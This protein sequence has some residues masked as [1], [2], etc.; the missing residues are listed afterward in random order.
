M[1][2]QVI[3]LGL[4]GASF[5][6]AMRKSFPE[7]IISGSDQNPE[8][9]KIALEKRIIDW[10]AE[11][12]GQAD[13]VIVAVPVNVTASIVENVLENCGADTLVMDMG[14]T[15]GMICKR[16]FGHPNRK[17]FLAA[18]PIAGTEFSGP[19]AG[20]PGLFHKKTMVLCETDLTAPHLLR[21]ALQILGTLDMRIR[22]M[23]PEAHDRHLA[24]VSHLS[25]ISSFMLGRTVLD[26]EES[27]RD[28]L[29]L[30][31][32]GFSSTVRLAKSSPATWTP[33]FEQNKA[34]VL[35][36]LNQ[37]I[38]HLDHFRQLL[39]KEDFQGIH[40]EMERV[41]PIKEILNGIQ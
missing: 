16:L 34:Q 35:E 27:E 25:H 18:H 5:A 30:A 37:Y 20:V 24:Y 8:H 13:L 2:I 17:H 31:G 9:M 41:Q 19:N 15:K 28:I 12:I 10:K 23:D 33:I 40:S 11:E 1:N 21:R 36:S 3:G 14:S 39:E 26:K 7:A 32:S 4:I 22:H 29:D 38:V 6:I